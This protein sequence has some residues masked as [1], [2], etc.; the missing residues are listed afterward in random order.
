MTYLSR[1][2][3]NPQRAQARRFL[4]DPQALHAAV[5]AGIP[6][7]PVTERVLWRLDA[8]RPLRPLVLVLTASQPSWEHLVE[9]AGW[10]SADD[11]DDP[12]ILVRPYEPLLDRLAAG[13]RYVFR[14]RANPVTATKDPKRLT[15]AQRNKLESGT[16]TR[17][18][19]VPHRTV[20]HQMG[21]LLKRTAK[22]G[23]SVPEASSTD[24]MQETVPDVRIIDRSRLQFSKRGIKGRVTIQTVTFEGHL[25]IEDVERFREVL[26]AGVGRAKAYGCGL[27]TLAPAD[28][29]AG[30]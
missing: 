6:Q 28:G 19:R 16:T 11:P 27:L 1:I 15:T 24:A 3:L 22:L 17:S 12:Q 5:L 14:L 10:P 18:R 23:F 2:R 29:T 21:W 8:D 4:S 9:Q 26:V 13:Q 7:Q 30:A 20:T 25:V